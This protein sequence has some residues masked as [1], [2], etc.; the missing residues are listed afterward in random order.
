MAAFFQ[1]K[2]GGQVETVHIFEID[3]KGRNGGVKRQVLHVAELIRHTKRKD[4]FKGRHKVGVNVGVVAFVSA[5]KLRPA[6]QH[7]RIVPP[8]DGLQPE[9]VGHTDQVVV[10]LV[11]VQV[12]SLGRDEAQLQFQRIFKGNFAFVV[13]VGLYHGRSEHRVVVLAT[14]VPVVRHVGLHKLQREIRGKL[15]EVGL[16][17]D[18][19]P[20]VVRQ[21]RVGQRLN[22]GSVVAQADVGFHVGGQ[23]VAQAGRVFFDRFVTHHQPRIL[24]VGG[25]QAAVDALAQRFDAGRHRSVPGFRFPAPRSG[26]SLHRASRAI[27]ERAYLAAHAAFEQGA[28]RKQAEIIRVAQRVGLVVMPRGIASGERVERSRIANV[29]RVGPAGAARRHMA[30]LLRPKGERSCRQERKDPKKTRQTWHVH[31]FLPRR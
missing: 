24:R 12:V 29:E 17:H 30:H 13:V 28:G 10:G 21:V 2:R 14:F 9:L 16:A 3:G 7:G 8:P 27:A 4:R 11:L 22:V 15:P 19:A 31:S 18:D 1:A 25:H 23:V 5:V 26:L 6:L 20:A